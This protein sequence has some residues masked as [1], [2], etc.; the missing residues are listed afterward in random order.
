MNPVHCKKTVTAGSTP[1]KL[2]GPSHTK[3]I[4]TVEGVVKPGEIHVI[5]KSVV[6]TIN[7]CVTDKNVA[8]VSLVF[9]CDHRL[10]RG[11]PCLTH[12]LWAQTLATTE[13]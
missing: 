13:R 6:N 1:R 4:P 9:F 10:I 12:G 3:H 5:L 2:K 8:F 7:S 11:L